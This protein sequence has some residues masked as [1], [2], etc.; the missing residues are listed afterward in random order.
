VQD[1]RRR[2]KGVLCLQLTGNATAKSGI[3]WHPEGLDL[4]VAGADNEIVLYE[5]HNWEAHCHLEEAHSAPVT[6]LAFSPNGG[7]CLLPIISVFKLPTQ[8]H[9]HGFWGTCTLLPRAV[10]VGVLHLHQ[11][12]DGGNVRKVIIQQTGHH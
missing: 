2:F 5:R 9:L 1:P 8:R 12:T 7:A 10:E 11:E 6:H 3:A 4:A